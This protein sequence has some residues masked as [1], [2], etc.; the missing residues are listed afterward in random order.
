MYL[1]WLLSAVLIILLA[2]EWRTRSF[3]LRV[4]ATALALL[5]WLFAQPNYTNVRRNALAMPVAERVRQV[6]RSGVL[7][8]FDSGVMTHSELL[9]EETNKGAAMNWIAL[10]SLVWLAC[11]PMRKRSANEAGDLSG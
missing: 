7:S 8:D 9:R 5:T 4:A 6:G 10:G 2:V 11:T 3:P 1:S